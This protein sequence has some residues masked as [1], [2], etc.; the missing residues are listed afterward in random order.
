MT[1]AFNRAVQAFG[2]LVKD[3]AELAHNLGREAAGLSAAADSMALDTRTLSQEMTGSRRE[4]EEVSTAV[5]GISQ[6]MG[7][8]AGN[9]ETARAQAQATLEATTQGATQGR[10]TADAMGGI[11]K[12]SD[13]I[14]SAV[15]IIQDIARQTNLLSL[16]AAI[17]AAKAGAQ[18]K[19]FAVVAEEVRKLAERSSAAAKE[20]AQLI[21]ESNVSVEEGDRTVA[22]TVAALARIEA[23]TQTMAQQIQALDQALE[24]Q[25]RTSESVAAQ[26][27]EVIA[28]LARNTEAAEALNHKVG[29]VSSTSTEQAEGAEKLL[30]SVRQ[31]RT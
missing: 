22:E 15:R 5:T 11:R 25:A 2:T 30:A 31:F 10:A 21:M 12:S 8:M 23:Q 3:M 16:N 17:E 26:T 14:A 28:R 24:A 4:A 9:L 6:A 20:I 13:K 29:A 7:R 27:Q 19:G 1:L 18:G